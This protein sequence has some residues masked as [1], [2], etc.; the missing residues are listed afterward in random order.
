VDQYAIIRAELE[1][2]GTRIGANDLFI[3]AIA[4]NYDM[5]LVTLNIRE[6]SRIAALQVED[7][8]L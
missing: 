7:W 3:A 8:H 1:R 5:I 2:T 4:K 6:F